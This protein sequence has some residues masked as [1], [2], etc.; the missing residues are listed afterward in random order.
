MET[1]QKPRGKSST[2]FPKLQVLARG[3]EVMTFRMGER[4]NA[5]TE[6]V[7]PQR[8]CGYAGRTQKLHQH[9]TTSQKVREGWSRQGGPRSGDK[10]SFYF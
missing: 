7:R 3:E 2:D 4:E 5:Y 8:Q 10:L 9:Q 1:D 6:Q